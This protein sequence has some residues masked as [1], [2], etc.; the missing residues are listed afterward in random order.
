MEDNQIGRTAARILTSMSRRGALRRL[1]AGG[2]AAGVAMGSQQ[3]PAQAQFAICA[4]DHGS[5]RTAC[6]RGDQPGAR[7]RRYERSR[8]DIFTRLRQSHAAPLIRDR[9]ALLAGSGGTESQP[10]RVAHDRPG[11]GSP[12]R[13]HR[14][15]VRHRVHPRLVPRDITRGGNEPT[16]RC[17]CRSAGRRSRL[18]QD[19]RRPGHAELGL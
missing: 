10:H 16:R 13:R 7:Y 19:F 9:T 1:G 2:L 3:R 5:D 8:R 12:H 15:L 17:G 4:G 14:R 18:R 11:W 6:D